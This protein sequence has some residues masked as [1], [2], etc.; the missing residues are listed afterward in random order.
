MRCQRKDGSYYG[1]SGQCRK[2][3]ES[4]QEDWREIHSRRGPSVE[5]VVAK[6]KDTLEGMDEGER[7]FWDSRIHESFSDVTLNKHGNGKPYTQEEKDSALLSQAKAWHELISQPQP[8][9]LALRNGEEMDAPS[10]MIPKV[11]PAGQKG[12][13]HPETGR[14]FSPPKDKSSREMG[15]WSQNRAGK[16]DTLRRVPAILSF[17]KEQEAKGGKWPTQSLPPRDD[18]ELDAK[19][20]LSG[21]SQS[22]RNAI[23]FNGLDA[24]KNEGVRLRRWYDENPTEKEGRLN[25]IVERYVAQGGRSG[26]SGQPIALPGVKPK[27]GEERTSVD[28]FNPIS[29]VRSEKEMGPADFR[30]LVDKGEN[31]LITEEGPNS[32]RGNREWGAFADRY[33][34]EAAK[35]GAATPALK[36]TPAPKPA[37]KKTQ[38]VPKSVVATPS[39]SSRSRLTLDQKSQLRA[40]MSKMGQ[41]QEEGLSEGAALSRLT[42]AQRALFQQFT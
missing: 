36:P 42:P 21:L 3:V 8:S 17:R 37:V 4:G 20:I 10:G 28:H 31:F 9:K 25:E 33:E 2:G 12:W 14:L 19:K 26:V 39:Q 32:N 41:L 5:A 35:G 6:L 11:T 18:I 24:T 16:E 13:I 27:P 23:V 38:S 1:T 7:E 22:D 34:K 15:V 40:A 30:R 29:S